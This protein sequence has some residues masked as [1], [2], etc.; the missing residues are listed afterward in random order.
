M[1]APPNAKRHPPAAFSHFAP[2]TV[3]TIFLPLAVISTLLLG[4]TFVLGWTI[5]DAAEPSL[6][7]Q[8]DHHLWTALAGMLFATLVHGLVMTYFIGTGRWFEE[9]TRAYSTTGES[10]IG[11]CYAASR[12]LK[13]RTVMTI[14]AGFTL[15]LA[16][17]TLGAAAD[18]AS[19]VGFTGWLG[20]APA[21]LH[22]LVALAAVAVN[23]WTHL[24]EYSALHENAKL[25]ERMMDQVRRIR[26]ERGLDD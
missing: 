4:T 15:L 17:G 1:A 19:P 2:H 18:P 26:A 22:L 7:H 24:A 6:S 5:Q 8:V 20:L 25:I 16:A 21:T 12:A 13:Y 9:T 3:K 11:E 10:V 23:S 14:V